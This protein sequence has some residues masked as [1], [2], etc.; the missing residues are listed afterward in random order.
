MNSEQGRELGSHTTLRDEAYEEIIGADRDLTPRYGWQY[1]YF[2]NTVKIFNCA[3]PSLEQRGGSSQGPDLS[4][5][6]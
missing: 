4:N 6:H 3:T 5:H 1:K 2:Y